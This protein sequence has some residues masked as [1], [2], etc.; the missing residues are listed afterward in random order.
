MSCVSKTSRGALNCI[1][2]SSC[3]GVWETWLSA[4]QPLLSTGYNL[5]SEMLS[6][7][8]LL[9]LIKWNFPSS[10]LAWWFCSGS[11]FPWS[12]PCPLSDAS[13]LHSAQWKREKVPTF[14]DDISDLFITLRAPQFTL[15]ALTPVAIVQL[16]KNTDLISCLCYTR[17]IWGQ[18]PHPCLFTV[19]PSTK[20]IHARYIGIGY[21]L[22]EFVVIVAQ[23]CLTLCIYEWKKWVLG[24]MLPLSVHGC[25]IRV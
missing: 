7:L 13:P 24:V 2:S 19:A 17:G 18:E 9:Y 10:H 1:Q 3:K 16:F 8:E 11:F 14:R 21:I 20:Y 12:C 22:F 5:E 4:L 23:L 6:Q 25:F 15:S